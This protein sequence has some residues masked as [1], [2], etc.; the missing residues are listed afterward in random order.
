MLQVTREALANVAKHAY[1]KHVWVDMECS[2]EKVTIRVRDDGRGFSTEGIRGHGMG[3]MSERTAMAGA[4]LDIS[5]AL[6]E[7]TQVVVSFTRELAPEHV[8]GAR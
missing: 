8:E 3:I 7:G 2:P 1:P 4:K 5:S 6:G